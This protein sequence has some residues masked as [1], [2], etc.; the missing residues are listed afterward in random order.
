MKANGVIRWLAVVALAARILMNGA[1]L[2]RP[3]SGPLAVRVLQI[4]AGV[5]IWTFLIRKVW[6]SPRR[7]GFGVGVLLLG[8]L[9]FQAYLWQIA[10]RAA[11]RGEL[12]FHLTVNGLIIS[13]IPTVVAAVLCILL[14]WFYPAENPQHTPSHS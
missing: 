8:T 1:G 11:E 9:A 10:L 2:L 3:S 6:I 14:R 5:V 7:W 4:V 13:A 12:P